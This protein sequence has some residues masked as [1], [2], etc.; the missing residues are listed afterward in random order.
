ML[1]NH[2]FG[3][4]FHSTNFTLSPQKFS[5][6]LCEYLEETERAL[7]S[8]TE[9]HRMGI[10]TAVAWAC[11]QQTTQPQWEAGFA[12]LGEKDPWGISELLG[13]VG[14]LRSLSGDL[15]SFVCS[16]TN[17]YLVSTVH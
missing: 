9:T 2:A 6:C 1:V 3:A 16:P 13:P 12:F 5:L 10:V 17:L 11:G 15:D 14:V 8:I 4:T 7:P